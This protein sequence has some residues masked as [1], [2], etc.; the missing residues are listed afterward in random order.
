M[1]K[2]LYD[3]PPYSTKIDAFSFGSILYEVVADRPVYDSS[4][5]SHEQII[6]KVLDNVQAEFPIGMS[7]DVKTLI[8][9]YWA[10][11]QRTL[12]RSVRSFG[13]SS[14]FGSQFGSQFF[15]KSTRNRLRDR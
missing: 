4:V 1:S 12:L 6:R 13:Q 9:R 5:L 2:E 11:S 14:R 7:A 10:G 3:D 15:P 8:G